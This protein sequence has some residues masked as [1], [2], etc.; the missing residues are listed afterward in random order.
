LNSEKV[1]YNATGRAQIQSAIEAA[2]VAA[3]G[4]VGV[5]GTIEPGWTV[6]PPPLDNLVDKAARVMRP[7]L[8]NAVMTGAVNSVEI[9]GTLTL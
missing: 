4:P 9:S 1:G 3:E 5:P 2:L 7:F 6:T 8:F